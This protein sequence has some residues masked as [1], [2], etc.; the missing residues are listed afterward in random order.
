MRK[1]HPRFCSSMNFCSITRDLVSARNG[2]SRNQI[3]SKHF[4]TMQMLHCYFTAQIASTCYLAWWD[5]SLHLFLCSSLCFLFIFF[6]NL[7]HKGFYLISVL[8][9]A[10]IWSCLWHVYSYDM[11]HCMLVANPIRDLPN[12]VGKRALDTTCT[13]VLFVFFQG[14]FTLRLS[15]GKNRKFT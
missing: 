5:K 8:Q 1:L 14:L 6:S 3:H 15:R 2:H 4:Q 11:R 12:F 13:V 9:Q 10:S 7:C